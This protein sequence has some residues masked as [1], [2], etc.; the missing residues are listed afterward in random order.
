MHISKHSIADRSG[1][2]YECTSTY[3]KLQV[4]QLG[5]LF[6]EVPQHTVSAFVHHRENSILVHNQQS[7]SSNCNA[8]ISNNDVGNGCYRA[9]DELLSTGG[10]GGDSDDDGIDRL[11][12]IFRWQSSS[13]LSL[14]VVSSPTRSTHNSLVNH[15]R[16]TD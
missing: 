12:V 5:S 14:W 7:E 11:P 4:I 15:S 1:C 8:N 9:S 6:V 16:V 3:I 2:L 10:I 13:S